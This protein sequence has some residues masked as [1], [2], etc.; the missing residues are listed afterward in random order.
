MS[1][2]ATTTNGALRSTA[3]TNMTSY[4]A[5]A[6]TDGWWTTSLTGIW[7]DVLLLPDG[8]AN[9]EFSVA[10]N[11]SLSRGYLDSKV[12]YD[13]DFRYRQVTGAAAAYFGFINESGGDMVRAAYDVRYF[14]SAPESRSFSEV[15]TFA[16]QPRFNAIGFSMVLTAYSR[17]IAQDASLF[18]G[19]NFGTANFGSTAGITGLRFF[20]ATGTRITKPVNYSFQR[21]TTFYDPNASTTT[22]P[23]PSTWMLMAGGLLILGGLTRRRAA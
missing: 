3:T 9:V 21:G 1:G 17:V 8:V 11:G 18:K 7:S 15:Y 22:V 19:P 6:V 23:E 14:D 12:V 10:V 20:D 4:T 5:N 16:L 2:S 13:P